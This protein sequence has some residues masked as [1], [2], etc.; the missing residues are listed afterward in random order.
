MSMD[1]I[2]QLPALPESFKPLL[3]SLRW[4]D[5]DTWEDREDVILSILNEGTLEQW[6]WIKEVYGDEEIRRV[7]NKHMISE[8][9]PESRRLVEL[10]FNAHITRNAR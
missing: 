1:K 7:L 9:H 8:F 5:L 10:I 2:N 6:R 4:S 3:W